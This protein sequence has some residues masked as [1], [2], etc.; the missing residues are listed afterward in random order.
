MNRGT[1]NGQAATQYRH[2]MQ[3]SAL[4]ETIPVVGSFVIAETGQTE[5]QDGSM[6]CMHETLVNAK[7]F[8]SWS[9]CSPSPC[10]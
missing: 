9:L 3:A 5:T 10:L 7:P 8:S 4:Y 1:L 2:P 6:Q